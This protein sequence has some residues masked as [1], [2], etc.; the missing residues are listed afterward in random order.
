MAPQA[1]K[2]FDGATTFTEIHDSVQTI[3]GNATW[4]REFL[5]VVEVPQKILLRHCYGCFTS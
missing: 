1:G 4:V 3:A 2:C 5:L